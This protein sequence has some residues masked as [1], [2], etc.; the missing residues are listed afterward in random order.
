MPS[1]AAFLNVNIPKNKK[2]EIDGVSLTTKI[3]ATDATADLKNRMIGIKWNVLNKNGKA[4]IWLAT[5]NNFK[6]GG[7]DDYKLMTEVPVTNG[8]VTIDVKKFPSG[9]Y[10]IVIELPYNFLNRWIIVK[11]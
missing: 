5:T 11:K 9:F 6:T 7:K 3:S 4:K 10:K 2:M 1:I 8:T